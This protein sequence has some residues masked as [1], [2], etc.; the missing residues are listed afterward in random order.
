[1]DILHNHIGYRWH[2]FKRVVLQFHSETERDAY[3]SAEV[4]IIDAISKEEVYSCSLLGEGNVAGWKNRYYMWFDFSNLCESGNYIVKVHNKDIK[5]V[6]APFTINEYMFT[7]TIFSDIIF[8]F[9]GQRCSGRWDEVDRAVPVYGN[10]EK[11]IDAHGGWFDASGDYSKYLSHLSYANYLNPQQ[12]PLSVY[13]LLSFYN[14]IMT[15]YKETHS[16]LG[17][18]AL[19]EAHWG[20]DFLMR[21]Q[22]ESGFFYMTLFDK[23]SKKS[24]ERMLCA[25]KTQQGDRLEEY[26]AGFRSGGGMAIAS[27]ANASLYPRTSSLSDSFTQDEYVMAAM[28]G[29]EHLIKH[30]EKYLDNK[31]ENL[32]DYYCALMASNNLYRATS[33]DYY[34]KEGAK[35]ASYIIDLYSDNEHCWHVEPGNDRPFFHASDTGLPFI[36]LVEFFEIITEE[37]EKEKV[38]QFL[39]KACN[40]LIERTEEVVNPFLLSRQR[41]KP[42]GKPSYNNFFVPH[43]NETGYWWQGENARLASEAAAC[44]MMKRL[45]EKRDGKT[46]FY[47]ALKRFGQSQIDFIFGCNPYNMCMM[48]GKGRNNPL[49][50]NHYPNAPGGICNG[51]TGGYQDEMDVDFLPTVVEGRG[52][53]RWRWSEQWIPHASWM[54]FALSEDLY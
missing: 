36:A 31:T 20:A 19:E 44:N 6:S 9:K 13:S 8:Y 34:T 29:Y 46:P 15:T 49:Y 23:W 27:L 21:M 26:Q 10:E 33:D 12:T 50:E 38:Y 47:Y 40:D 5:E 24:E 54:L 3:K 28:K 4:C 17:E 30:N 37:K 43:E 48:D 2:D 18:R 32:I 42:V 51:I 39:K 52:D 35:W 41:V 11:R 16:M 1:M 53:H 7:N 25:F 45:V 22:D 14:S